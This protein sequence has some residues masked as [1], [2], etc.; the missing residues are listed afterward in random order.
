MLETIVRTIILIG[1]FGI[2]GALTMV[3]AASLGSDF[4][5]SFPLGG[6]GVLFEVFKVLA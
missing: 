6:I 2:S 4:L 1:S 3:F 5:S